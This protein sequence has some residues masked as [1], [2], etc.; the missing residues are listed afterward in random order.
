[1]RLE[2]LTGRTFGRLTVVSRAENSKGGKARWLCRCQCGNECIVYSCSLKSGNTKS[3]GCFRKEENHKR[4]MTHGMSK[5][6]LFTIWWAMICRC[7]N[8]N[9]KSYPNYGGRG[10]CVCDEW[11]DSSAFFEW[12]LN[13]GYSDG[14]SIERIDVDEGYSP[15]NCKWITR[16]KQAHNKRNNFM[17]DFEGEQKRLVQLCE[18]Y[19]IDYS[20]VYQRVRKLGWDTKKALTTPARKIEKRKQVKHG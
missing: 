19:G 9:N 14:L 8:E 7:E 5:S 6:K 16:E 3:C 13:N 15:D 20:T 12:A 10:I 18:E 4:A 11:H 2:D 17:V 1:M